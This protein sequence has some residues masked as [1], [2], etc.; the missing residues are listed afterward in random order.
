MIH[1]Y[2]RPHSLQMKM[3][4]SI[5]GLKE[6][7][8]FGITNEQAFNKSMFSRIARPKPGDNECSVWEIPINIDC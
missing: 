8:V 5:H 3:G 2:F 6:L 4:N 1:F 7:N